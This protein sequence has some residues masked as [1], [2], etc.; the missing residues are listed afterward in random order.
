M[1]LSKCFIFIF[2]TY[3]LFL[4]TG[5]REESGLLTIHV[6]PVGHGD[7]SIIRLPGG[8]TL[9]IDNGTPQTAELIARYLKT[10]RV[11]QIDALIITHA[12]DN[13]YGILSFLA[14]QVR[15]RNL[16]L[17]DI[18][19]IRDINLIAELEVLRR[20][21]IEPQLLREGD[22]PALDPEV[23]VKILHPSD[24]LSGDLN[25]D[26]IVTLLMFKNQTFLFPGDITPDVQKRIASD[27]PGNMPASFALLPHHGD[28]LD[29]LFVQ[30]VRPGIKIISSGPSEYRLPKQETLDSFPENLYRTDRDGVLIFQS[31]GKSLTRATGLMKKLKTL[32]PDAKTKPA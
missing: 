21:G 30:I 5:C 7:A 2:L 28:T 9:M 12:H 3:S 25:R 16:Y 11:K 15:I 29:P 27:W 31:D 22:E 32:P 13:H 20:M 6:L 26:S 10:I 4:T 23:S 17:N 1:K 19:H 24:S 8:K 18:D 14:K